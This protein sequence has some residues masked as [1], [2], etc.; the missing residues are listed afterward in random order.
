MVRHSPAM[1]YEISYEKREEGL[2]MIAAI[3]EF[4]D[5][6]KLDF[7]EVVEVR[8][9]RPIK[10]RYSYHYMQ[11]EKTVFRYDNAQ[12]H[13]QIKTFPHHKHVGRKVV[14][15]VEPTLKQV[16]EEITTLIEMGESGGQ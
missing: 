4:A 15:A 2:G 5:G 6:S 11:G 3:L 9:Y 1:D 14:A 16:L 10:H 12:H 8:A 7:K 13:R